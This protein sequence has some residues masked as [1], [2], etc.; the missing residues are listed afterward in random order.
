MN[1]KFS[2]SILNHKGTIECPN[3]HRKLE[4]QI[5]DAANNKTLKCECGQEIK[6]SGPEIMKQIEKIQKQLDDLF[7]GFS[8]KI[9]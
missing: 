3:C 6:L 5:R 7:K 9:G 1:K 2:E 4:F 8:R